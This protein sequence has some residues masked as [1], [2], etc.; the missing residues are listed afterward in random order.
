MTSAPTRLYRVAI[1]IMRPIFPLLVRAFPSFAT[2]SARLGRAMLRVV[3][4]R[5]GQFIL[6][7][8]DINRI[9]A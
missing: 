6:E 9:G 3:Q 2:T 7:P 8:A 4:G 5:A 1:V